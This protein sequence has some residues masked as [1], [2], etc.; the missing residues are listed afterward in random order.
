MLPLVGEQTGDA[1]RSD[2]YELR[3]WPIHPKLESSNKD[4]RC[5]LFRPSHDHLQGVGLHLGSS[6]LSCCAK[7]E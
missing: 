6:W 1:N 2:S 3:F 5:S 7:V 4:D